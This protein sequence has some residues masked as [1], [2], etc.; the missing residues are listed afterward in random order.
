MPPG[1]EEHIFTVKSVWNILE[2]SNMGMIITLVDIV[3]FFDREDIYDVM[4]TLHNI[5]VDS[6]AMV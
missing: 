6:K 3:A 1:P 2:M 4:N 5:G